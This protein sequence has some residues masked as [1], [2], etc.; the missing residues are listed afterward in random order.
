MVAAFDID[1]ALRRAL[2]AYNDRN[3][4]L[5]GDLC[6]AVLEHDNR[7]FGAYSLLGAIAMIQGQA[8]EAVSAFGKAL[9]SRP[10]DA[11]TFFQRGR[12]L[13]AL[14]DLARA[15]EDY[16]RALALQPD[17]PEALV[18][19]AVGLKAAGQVHG[20]QAAYEQSLQVRRQRLALGRD[21]FVARYALS[22]E[23]QQMGDL[24]SALALCREALAIN[25]DYVP[26]RG[27]LAHYQIPTIYDDVDEVATS[28]AAFAHEL[29]ALAAWLD[30][31][32][33]LEAYLAFETTRVFFLAYQ[34]QTNIELLAHYGEVCAR[35][36]AR[37]QRARGLAAP[38]RSCR[39]KVRLGIVLAHVRSGPVW[40]TLVRGWV[41]HVDRGAFDVCIFA[42]EPTRGEDTDAMRI[43]A[44]VLD[45]ADKDLHESARTILDAAIDVLVYPEVG[46]NRKVAVLASLRLAPVQ[47]ASWG[48]PETTGLP[49][50]DYFL[51]AQALEPADAQANYTERLVALPGLGCC[52]MAD[53][54][55]AGEISLA[56]FGIDPGRPVLIC[57]GTPFKYAAPFDDVLVEIAARL[58]AGQLVFFE[59][60]RLHYTRKLQ[61]RLRE[62]FMRRGMR[63]E[64]HVVFAPWLDAS[65]FVA[66]LKRSTL[67]LDTIGFSGFNTAMRAI[68][69]SLPIVTREGRY[70]RGR[71]ASG[72]L[73]E[74]GLNELIAADES[75]YV[76]LAVEL[77]RDEAYNAS[78]RQGIAA[79]RHS[80][81]QHVEAVRAL[82]RFCLEALRKT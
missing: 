33:P 53:P 37:W 3:F 40:D 75:A 82:E 36:M 59:Y 56:T 25:P 9:V 74:L 78:I 52:Y 70:L 11:Q 71:L 14:G 76:D 18:H 23:F 69:A 81:Y 20:A 63:M 67:M 46:M 65:A 58:P 4:A 8:A 15:L 61:A 44:T 19:L 1:E 38:T 13:A 77:A 26:A 12:A 29:A 31:R 55:A 27:A 51:S 79:R 35:T 60:E 2:A 10:T 50:I 22:K 57:P 7:H 64:E 54:A 73:R 34:E 72:I 41:E 5:A 16:R 66:L 47:A 43:P 45:L 49:T 28:R 30:T 32:P 62:A 17:H 80:L 21:D 48:H 6:R 68:E 39:D 42:I 24:A